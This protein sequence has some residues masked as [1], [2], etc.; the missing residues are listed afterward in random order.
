MAA[1]RPDVIRHPHDFS[2]KFGQCESLRNEGIHEWLTNIGFC[3][4]G[5]ILY[6]LHPSHYINKCFEMLAVSS[7]IEYWADVFPAEV[8]EVRGRHRTHWTVDIDV[9]LDRRSEIRGRSSSR[10]A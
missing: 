1:A 6:E 9:V 2:R 10:K 7:D 3:R 5:T 8:E 4:A